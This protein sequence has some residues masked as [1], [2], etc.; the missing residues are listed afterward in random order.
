MPIDF[1]HI[2]STPHLENFVDDRNTHLALAHLIETDKAYEDFYRGQSSST[3][4]L[5]NSA[6]EMYKQGRPMYPSHKLIEMGHR[7][8]ADYIVMSDYPNQKGQDT[9]DAAI[10]S[11][12]VLRDEGFKTF[13]V[14]QSVIGDKEDYIDTFKWAAYSDAVDYIG[15]SILGVPNAYGVE[16]DNKLQRFLSRWKMMRELSDRGL[17]QVARDNNKK[18]HFLG[19]VDGPN[20]IALMADHAAYIDT[21][22]SSA[23]VWAGLNGISFDSSPTG[24]VNGKFEE[25]VDFDFETC[26]N[27]LLEI[28]KCN[29]NY[30]DEICGAAQ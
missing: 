11:A 19:M 14:P 17:L 1:C 15:I 5:D 20:E 7:I 13:F 28:A 16:K 24:L 18:I 30:I 12:P 2:V 8:S 26:D 21:W 4:I 22:D 25:E 23:A 6:F 29:V 10:A 27:E 3:I 9:I